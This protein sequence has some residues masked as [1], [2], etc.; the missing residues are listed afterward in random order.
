MPLEDLIRTST[1]ADQL[2]KGSEVGISTRTPH[3]SHSAGGGRR[4]GDKCHHQKAASISSQEE[5]TG[6]LLL[7]PAVQQGRLELPTPLLIRPSKKTGE[8]AANRRGRTASAHRTWLT[9]ANGSSIL[10]YSTRL[11]LISI[12]GRRY[13]WNFVIVDV[14]TP[15]L[16]ADS[17]AH[18]G[19]A[20]DI[21]RKR[22]LDTNSCQSIPLAPGPNVPT[23]CSVVPH[24]Y[25]QLLKEFPDVFKP[26]LRQAPGTPAKH[27]IYHHIKTKGPPAHARFRRLPPRCLQEAK[28]AF[29]EMQRMG[30]CKKASSPWTS[31]LHMVPVTPEDI[32]KTAIITPS[33][34]MSH[35]EHQRHIQV[36]LQ[37]LQEKCLVVRFDKCTFGVKKAD[38]LGHEIS[39]DG[40]HP[41]SSKVAAVTR[42]PAPTSVKAVQEFLRMPAAGLLPDEGRPHRGNCLGSSPT[43]D[44]CPA[45][46]PAEP[47]WGRSSTASPSPSPSS[48]KCSAP[49]RPATALS[50]GNSVQY[51]QLLVH[52]FTKQGD[53]WSSRQQRHLTAVA[54]FTCSI[55]YLPGRKSPVADA[56]SRIELNVVQLGIN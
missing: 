35:K 10:S 42:F 12:L 26:E 21:G 9:A 33:G 6:P 49:W 31:P 25:A 16:C 8:A 4:G 41:L 39:P 13:S 14:R 50:T 43:D 2:C 55:K 53:A 46:S 44:G 27:G 36:V 22:L 54:E 28:D 56:L 38:F 52:A 11:L 48:A 19:L 51:H 23:I 17:L 40:V 1:A 30:I 34:P 24:Q 3:Q 20:V 47:S 18:F 29:A 5:P 32:P 7:P 45:A 15:L 37:R